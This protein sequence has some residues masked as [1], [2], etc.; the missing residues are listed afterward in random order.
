MSAASDADKMAEGE[1]KPGRPRRCMVGPY[2]TLCLAAL[3]AT[4]VVGSGACGGK[5]SATKTTASRG[6]SAQLGI[7]RVMSVYLKPGHP[8]AVDFPGQLSRTDHLRAD[9]GEAR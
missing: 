9:A 4:V 2:R 3:L 8:F 6:S 5:S 1:H 7:S